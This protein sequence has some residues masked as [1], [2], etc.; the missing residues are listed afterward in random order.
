[1]VKLENVKKSFSKKLLFEIPTLSL[2]TGFTCLIGAS[3]C[4]KTTLGRII[5]GLEKA[6]SGKIHGIEGES[7]VLFQESRLLPSLTAYGN[8]TAVCRTD[9]GKCLGRELLSRL[10]F[11]DEDINK[12]PHELSGGMERRVAIVR[13]V[14]FAHENKGSFAL[15]DEPFTGLDPDTRRIAADV[16]KEYLSDRAVLVITHD[17]EEC[18][19]LGG[20][21]VEFLSLLESNTEI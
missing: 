9:E 17:G 5:C 20:K 10:L 14:V 3:G 13:A 18:E 1:M 16:L 7:V 15:L 11:T 8:V 21:T 19:L 2:D 12:R 6:D 4:G